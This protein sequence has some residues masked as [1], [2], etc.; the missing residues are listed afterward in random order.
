MYE[1]LLAMS[2]QDP[3]TVATTGP[4]FESDY[5][6]FILCL[7]R[8]YSDWST[9]MMIGILSE[10]DWSALTNKVLSDFD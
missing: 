9:L 3:F 10:F 1:C 4:L 6:M 5:A 8:T 7:M 2:S